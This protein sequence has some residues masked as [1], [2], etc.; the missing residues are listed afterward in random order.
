MADTVTLEC[1]EAID[2]CATLVFTS[3]NILP[4]NIMRAEMYYNDGN[5]DP[6]THTYDYESSANLKWMSQ[7]LKPSDI[8]TGTVNITGLNNGD[9][10]IFKL[11]IV[12]RN[13][14]AQI[15][16]VWSNQTPDKMVIPR[17]LAPEIVSGNMNS[18]DTTK[19]Y[20]NIS[21]PNNFFYD[22]SAAYKLVFLIYN[23]DLSPL[24]VNKVLPVQ[25]FSIAPSNPQ[26][27][28]LLTE[29]QNDKTYEISCFCSSN[30]SNVS[31]V[32]NTILATLSTTPTPPYL[33]IPAFNYDNGSV[34]LTTNLLSVGK[35][36]QT[37]I[38]FVLEILDSN[39]E[40]IHSIQLPNVIG[41]FST[42]T[43]PD[44]SVNT[45]D[46]N[47]INY[48]S[49]GN[50]YRVRF[51]AVSSSGISALSNNIL[52]F[53]PME[54]ATAPTLRVTDVNDL[55]GDITFDW[56][57]STLYGATLYNYKLELLTSADSSEPYRQYLLTDRNQVSNNLPT[58]TRYYANVTPIVYDPNYESVINR[59]GVKYTIVQSNTLIGKKSSQV[60]AT[61]YVK[62][63]APTLA[64]SYA[65][66]YVDSQATFTI[67][68][69]D[70]NSGIL[71]EKYQ[72]VQ[73][74]V[75]GNQVTD[76][77]I[78]DVGATESLVNI[79][80]DSLDNGIAY[81]FA[82]RSVVNTGTTVSTTDT[83]L[84]NKLIYGDLGLS[85][86]IIPWSLP[87]APIVEVYATGNHFITLTLLEQNVIYT[88]G[89]SAF[90]YFTFGDFSSDNVI[91][92]IS[93]P[94]HT[95]YEKTNGQVYTIQ[96]S[97]VYFD[98]NTS[99]NIAV[100]GNTVYAEPTYSDSIYKPRSVVATA[101]N[102]GTITVKW[103]APTL[104]NI[105]DK[106][107]FQEYKIYSILDNNEPELEN[108]VFTSPLEAVIL[109]LDLG[110]RYTIKVEAVYRDQ[111]LSDGDELASDVSNYIYPYTLA[112]AP[113]LN[114]VTPGDIKITV[115]YYAPVNSGG[116]TINGYRIYYKS[117]TN[118]NTVNYMD[119][120]PASLSNIL[121]PLINGTRY[122]VAVA[123]LTS[124]PNN[125]LEELEG[126]S[127]L[128]SLYYVPKPDTI[129][130]I[131]N[132][133]MYSNASDVAHDVNTGSVVLTW[134]EITDPALQEI[135]FKY[136]LRKI[137]VSSLSGV[138]V[139]S[140]SAIND[141]TVSTIE[142]TDM[143][144]SSYTVN[145]LPLG[146]D[147]IFIINLKVNDP[148]NSGSYIYGP[149][150]GP[151]I[152]KPYDS[153]PD[154]IRGT[155]AQGLSSQVNVTWTEQATIGGQEVANYKVYQRLYTVNNTEVYDPVA[156]N[157]YSPALLNATNGVTYQYYVAP[158]LVT[159]E[160]A[161]FSEYGTIQKTATPFAAPTACVIATDKLSA[162]DG[163]VVI[164]MIS[165]SVANGSPI[166]GYHLYENGIEVRDNLQTDYVSFPVTR[167]EL[168]NNTVYSYIANPVYANLNNTSI[169]L[170]GPDSNT[171]TKNPFRADI[172]PAITRI[173]NVD[174]T[175]V[176]VY[177]Y[178]S[179]DVETG[180][181]LETEKL[182]LNVNGSD[183]QVTSNP[184]ELTVEAG[185]LLNLKMRSE[186][187]NP[188]IPSDKISSDYSTVE[189]FRAYSVP[190]INSLQANTVGDSIVYL[191]LK[192]IALNSHYSVFKK[193]IVRTY[194]AA[195]NE[196]RLN[197]LIQG[198]EGE[199]S[200]YKQG[201]VE[202]SN[203]RISGLTN[204]TLYRFEVTAVGGPQYGSLD[205]N[206][207]NPDLESSPIYIVERP[208]AVQV[209]RIES[210]TLTSTSI[211]LQVQ[212]YYQALTNVLLFVSP[213]LP[214]YYPNGSSPAQLYYETGPA[215]ASTAG[216]NGIM[217]ITIQL[218]GITPSAVQSLAAIALNDDGKSPTYF[219]PSAPNNTLSGT[220]IA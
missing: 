65:Q 191:G 203:I 75:Y 99:T 122:K 127:V 119:F 30:N 29:L 149:P 33:P 181:L 96:P 171:A 167:N 67:T 154:A 109:G 129:A 186:F 12:Y 48:F 2:G 168:D 124:N 54:Y 97:A 105:D 19:Y 76:G 166:L 182:Y 121:T 108:P 24:N 71:F 112:D 189:S 70:N 100:Q 162:V 175:H 26:T 95:F 126:A 148:N 214:I 106:M 188:N 192:S 131:Q 79:V 87:A 38:Y 22:P 50:E 151:V 138:T 136:Q 42:T 198:E 152:T 53:T 216:Y 135:G 207:P 80:I 20:I 55:N 155:N 14:S 37:W 115:T 98:P 58:R 82:A 6:S 211:I 170:E 41:M 91:P 77:I 199:V 161:A 178:F 114:N 160:E 130:T 11:M 163:E 165:A 157:T 88:T 21:Y 51:R 57:E 89:V 213:S 69:Q 1:K 205:V 9:T 45:K 27:E 104:G 72:I 4:N 17:Q 145:D 43:I 73:L 187:S 185:T 197:D 116:G 172:A 3:D 85:N 84:R 176:Q 179:A 208:T 5:M 117:G 133:E 59:L 74:D 217:N 143:Q 120:K 40:P 90:R 184:V 194:L 46:I 113:V 7:S 164:S 174:E 62:M 215:S 68:A 204:G 159:G 10:Y 153:T 44:Y 35:A 139:N 193:Y 209:P 36:E 23:N 66:E 34:T 13:S 107:V 180:L 169:K 201:D 156:T 137:N 39:D 18:N 81:Y 103:L 49:T 123:A 142:I 63:T 56:S 16:T 173:R 61:S 102:N 158:V 150:S 111:V 83:N 202:I 15:F 32:S 64:V 92:T 25:E 93:N 144:A 200:I 94:R 132:F 206:N 52:T 218:N 219:Y 128:S 146:E 101:S 141:I 195:T 60:Y 28:F 118:Y 134:T 190:T 210:Y 220:Y 147:A 78:L 8:K 125:T 196:S 177:Y 110:S 183:Q 140:I 212:S 86:R 31:I 47:L